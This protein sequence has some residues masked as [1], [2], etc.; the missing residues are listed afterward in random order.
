[1]SILQRIKEYR[2][3]IKAKAV[4]REIE[5]DEQIRRDMEVLKEQKARLDT[6]DAYNKLRHEVREKEHPWL[7]KLKQNMGKNI[8]KAAETVPKK[9]G[10]SRNIT[11]S[12]LPEKKDNWET[13]R[14]KEH[15]WSL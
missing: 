12:D 6:R 1:M 15:D 8:A 13:G 5:R 10:I 2:N 7:S 11:K 3:D 9:K 14:A 4:T